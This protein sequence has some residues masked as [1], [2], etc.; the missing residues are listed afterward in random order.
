MP[1]TVTAEEGSTLC[2]LAIAEGHLNCKTT[3]EVE[4][5]KKYIGKFLRAGDQVEIPDVVVAKVTKSTDT[6]NTGTKKNSP[7][8]DV[9][10][11][12]GEHDDKDFDSDNAL[13]F[14]NVSNYV[15]DKAGTTGGDAFPT[16]FGYNEKAHADSDA[17]RI[18]VTDPAAGGSV[19]VKL[20]AV[21]AVATNSDGSSKYD[22]FTSGSDVAK[23]KIDAVECKALTGAPKALRSK[24]LRLVTCSKDHAAVPGQGLLVRDTVDDGDEQL[25]ILDQ[26]VR[27][28]YEVASCPCSPKCVAV[29]ELPIGDDRKRLKLSVH[30]LKHPTSGTAVMTVD[31]ARKA[32]LKFVRRYYAQAE[33]GVKFVGTKVREVKAP[34]NM[35]MVGES[36]AGAKAQGGKTISVKVTVDGVEKQAAIT[37]DANDVPLATAEKL[38]AAINAQFGSP[39]PTLARASGNKPLRN[40]SHGSADVLVGDLTKQTVT[41]ERVKHDDANHEIEVVRIGDTKI[42]DFASNR[43][44]IGTPEERILIK[45][46]N[47]GADRLD[48]FIIGGFNSGTLGEAFRVRQKSGE[49]EAERPVDELVNSVIIGTRGMAGAD[50]QSTLCHEFAHVL[51]DEGSHPNIKTEILSAEGA[52]GSDESP[53]GGP[54]R[55]SV[56]EL[57]FTNGKRLK[58]VD[59]LRG[60]NSDLLDSWS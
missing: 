7:P 29:A 24:Y 39:S 42:T 9:R 23:R 1:K 33:I 30:I 46:Y 32:I 36:A 5:N 26:K 10:F 50:Y 28:S 13:T 25:E 6:K 40:D 53:V 12:R 59:A 41:I 52:T 57:E 45:N 22:P 3:R 14:L 15:S 4:A 54:K 2:Q 44:W 48:L 49:P 16:A 34:A 27:V 38:A 60:N 21:R 20:E 17:F 43:S 11:V 31:D 51:M 56:W 18:E 8:V 35:I 19:N 55:V 47:T 58:C 37:T